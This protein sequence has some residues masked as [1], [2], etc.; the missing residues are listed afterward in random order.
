MKMEQYCR[1]CGTTL[2]SEKSLNIFSPNSRQLLQ[3]VRTITN[4][5]VENVACFPSHICLNCQE[6]LKK[7]QSFRRR[8]AKIEK[9]LSKHKLNLKHDKTKAEAPTSDDPLGID[10]LKQESSIKEEPSAHLNAVLENQQLA[11][12]LVLKEPEDLLN[13]PEYLSPNDESVKEIIEEIVEHE[14]ATSRPKSKAKTTSNKQTMRLGR[15][16]IHVKVIDDKE[17]PKRIMDRDGQTAKPCI[18]E[19]C[20]RQFRDSSNLNVHLLRHSGTKPY[21]CEQCHEK[22]YTLHLLRRHQL[23]HTEGPYPCTFCGLEYSTNSSR[24]RH[25]R[26]ACKKGRAPQSKWKIIKNGERTFHCEVCDLWFLRAG[27][28]TQHINSSSHLV[29][30]RRK[31]RKSFKNSDK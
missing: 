29:N 10:E 23:K 30:E 15:K 14:P 16:L 5:W 3:F 1:T 4:C 19:H 21:E 20:G 13:A 24:V 12:D 7:L 6:L 22:C 25:E 18:C 8:C 31:Q 26:E 27:N 17:Q 28:Y 2:I 11:V 9:Y